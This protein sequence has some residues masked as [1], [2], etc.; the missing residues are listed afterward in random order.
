MEP[1]QM[2]IN[3]Y[4]HYDETGE[5][6]LSVCSLPTGDF[7]EV[8]RVANLPNGQLRASTVGRIRQAGYEIVRSE[9]PPAHADLML[10]GEP[11]D[12]DWETLRATF[13]PPVPNPYQRR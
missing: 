7:D 11:N 6:A 12:H 13:D 2:E 3:A 1:R 4:T 10:M 9:P 5:Y 8:A